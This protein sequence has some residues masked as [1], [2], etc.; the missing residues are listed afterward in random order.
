MSDGAASLPLYARVKQGIL[1]RIAGG[2]WPPGARVPSEHAL[3]A[4]TGASR[5]TV[6]RALRE[7]A[8]EGRIH[9]VQGA[10]SFV[11]EPK[12]AS[13]LME[14]RNIADDVATHGHRH[15]M[16]LL[17]RE[18]RSARA[19]EA[20]RLGLAKRASIFHTLVLHE[21]DGRPVQLE[22]RLVNPAVAPD[23]G[24]TDLTSETPN[25]YLTRVAPAS[26][27]EHAV[28]A[29]ACPPALAAHLDIDAGT[30]CLAVDRRTWFGPAVA[31]TARL[32]H[33]GP[34]YRL[35]AGHPPRDGVPPL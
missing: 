31:S 26:A 23:Y 22:D 24:A 30:P 21:A 16:R 6:N 25:A 1:D 9:R 10:G 32:I 19:E 15:A 14:L 17:V 3:V 20:T 13:D 12:P 29:I 34:R 2:D 28:E 7:L 4:E 11:A 33:P 27:V 18:E 35:T 8:A 5:M